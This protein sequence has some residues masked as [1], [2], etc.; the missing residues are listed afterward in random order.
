MCFGLDQISNWFINA[1]RGHLP[2]MVS[3]A[4]A[5]MAARDAQIVERAHAVQHGGRTDMV[6]DSDSDHDDHFQGSF[7]TSNGFR[8]NS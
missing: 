4:T 7:P 3:N 6:H 8:S 5:E 1:R 2:M